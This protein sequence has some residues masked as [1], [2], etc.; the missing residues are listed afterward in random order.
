MMKKRSLMLMLAFL[1]V[2]ASAIVPSKGV[3]AKSN[4]CWYGRYSEY[5]KDAKKAIKFKKG[6]IVQ[7]KGKFTF[8]ATRH[9]YCKEN[10]KINKT[11]RIAKNARFF[12]DDRDGGGSFRRIS[13][14]AFKN[15]VYSDVSHTALK[16]RNGKI[17]KG[18]A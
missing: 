18:V 14:K 15:E 6:D 5:A 2:F 11:F 9:A 1:L 17:V 4:K 10:N 8:S 3:S 13:K 12:V 7:L 16:I